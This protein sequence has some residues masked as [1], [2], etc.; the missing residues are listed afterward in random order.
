D[1]IDSPSIFYHDGSNMVDTGK[2]LT[3]SFVVVNN[4]Y[5]QGLLITGEHL[6]VGGKYNFI[7]KTNIE[8]S[9]KT[10]D[11]Y[12]RHI[13]GG[14]YSLRKDSTYFKN[15]IFV[16]IDYLIEKPGTYQFVMRNDNN[17][18]DMVI[19]QTLAAK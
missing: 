17:G 15:G 2:R 1:L 10:D 16:I 13:D 19:H 7:I 11:F 9:S 8:D 12:I 3:D 14:T 18:R 4:G 6:E 5:L